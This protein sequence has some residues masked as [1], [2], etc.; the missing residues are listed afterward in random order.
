MNAKRVAVAFIL[1]SLSG[2]MT[3]GGIVATKQPFVSYDSDKLP[4][5]LV[6]CIVNTTADTNFLGFKIPPPPVIPDPIGFR[7]HWLQSDQVF[8]K[9]TPVGIGSHLDFYFN[10]LLGIGERSTL[11]SIVKSCK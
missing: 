4:E 7:I 8:A 3:N 2:C 9:I 1:M 11:V 5:V 6:K 10:T